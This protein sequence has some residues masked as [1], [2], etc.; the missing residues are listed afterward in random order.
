MTLNLI[1]SLGFSNLNLLTQVEVVNGTLY[2]TI[3]DTTYGSELWK[4]DSTSGQ[5]SLVQDYKPSMESLNPDNFTNFNGKLYFS[6]QGSSFF[7]EILYEFSPTNQIQPI[8]L[9]STFGEV[10]DIFNFGDSLYI[11]TKPNIYSNPYAFLTLSKVNL[12]T[13]AINNLTLPTADANGPSYTQFSEFTNVGDSLYFIGKEYASAGSPLLKINSTGVVE[14]LD[15]GFQSYSGLEVTNL[16]NVNGVLYF[17]AAFPWTQKTLYKFDLNQTN[18]VAQPVDLGFTVTMYDS[19]AYVNGNIY[20]SAY[21]DQGGSRLV[22]L[23]PATGVTSDVTNPITVGLAKSLTNVNGNLYFTGMDENFDTR[24]WTYDGST[25]TV[26]GSVSFNNPEIKL[27]SINER[28]LWIDED[29]NQS[30]NQ[31]LFSWTTNRPPVIT[32][33][34]TFSVNENSKNSTVVGIVAAT[35]LDNNPFSNWQITA[36]NTNDAF[37]INATTGQITVNNAIVLDFE[38][39]PT[40]NLTLTVSDGTVTSLA[41]TIT[42]NLKDLKELIYTPAAD[43][44]SGTRGN[45]YA[46]LLDGN[47]RFNAG[48]GHDYVEGGNGDDMIYGGLGNDEFYGGAGKDRLYGDSGNDVIYGNEDNDLIYGGSGNDTLNGGA[49]ND[50]LYGDGGADTF[51]LRKGEGSDIIRNYKAGTDKIDLG[52]LAVTLNQSGKNVLIQDG[53]DILAT[54]MGVTTDQL[55]II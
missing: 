27:I 52:G 4:F 12:T 34:Q 25:V 17:E 1:S 14:R 44:A 43:R 11:A 47:D 23:A 49:G 36:G 3:S 31:Q 53:S 55:T 38:T 9:S 51:V 29:T 13:G 7:E 21:D 35:D 48:G 41:Q 46:Y 40:F 20:V 33:G 45:D 24:L 37:A 8:N 28:I 18:A 10:H 50:I 42:I 22:K 5:A 15:L 26:V 6:G 32:N 2:F 39:N 30:G 19:F 16:T 54:V